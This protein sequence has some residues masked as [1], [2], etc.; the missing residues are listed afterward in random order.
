M[1]R[2]EEK[3]VLKQFPRA[4]KYNIEWLYQ[5]EMGPCSVW[6]A[7]FLAEKITIEPWMRVLDLGCGKAIS[8]IFLAKE[9]KAKIWATDLWIS[10]TDNWKRVKEANI[11]DLVFPVYSD[12]HI[13]PYPKEFFDL[14]VSFDAYQYF[15]TNQLYIE[16]IS[17][18]LKKDGIIGI[19]VPGVNKEWTNEGIK[20]YGTLW[21]TEF[22]VF[23]TAEWWKDLWEKSGY[24]K[25]EIADTMPNGYENWLLWDKTLKEEGVLGRSGDVEFIEKTDDKN[26]TFIRVIAK[27]I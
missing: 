13:L 27:R 4:S 2:I 26:L 16:Y 23:H 22:T 9:F 7:E 18:F 3:L 21:E 8:S 11:E 5:N 6:L 20:K 14:L 19:V 17:K 12:A 1:T 25:V 24:V 15:G 10:A